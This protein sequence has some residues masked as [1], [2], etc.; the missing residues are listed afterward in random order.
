MENDSFTDGINLENNTNNVLP[1]PVED[2][3]EKPEN[4]K[5][6]TPLETEDGRPCFADKIFEALDHLEHNFIFRKMGIAFDYVSRPG[7]FPRSALPKASEVKE[8]KPNSA[9]IGT[10]I[11]ECIN[12]TCLLLDG[13]LTRLEL[14]LSRNDE[15]RIM[16]RLVAGLI[17]LGTISQKNR[18]V[19]GFTPDGRSYYN[20]YS[21][22]N[23]TW[24]AHGLYRTSI[25]P[26][27]SQ[28]SQQKL[29]DIGNKWL[30]ALKEDEFMIPGIVNDK[31]SL[32]PLES[33]SDEKKWENS[34]RFLHI[35]AV[36][37]F[38]TDNKEWQELYQQYAFTETGEFSIKADLPTAFNEP[39]KLLSLQIALSD[40][41]KIRTEE[42]ELMH[43]NLLR[44]KIAYRCVDTLKNFEP[45]EIT[46]NIEDAVLDWREGFPAGDALLHELKEKAN[47]TW[48]QIGLEMQRIAPAIEAA[49]CIM[50]TEDS[51]LISE[52]STDIQ[53]IIKNTEWSKL[54]TAC[55]I[56]PLLLMHALGYESSLWDYSRAISL[57][58]RT[59]GDNYG[60]DFDE[61]NREHIIDEEYIK[62]HYKKRS[63]IFPAF[64]ENEKEGGNG[65][66]KTGGKSRT[67]RHKKRRTRKR[68]K[69]FNK[70][71]N[72]SNTDKKQ[73]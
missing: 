70:N 22:M 72:S 42:K 10:G 59:I 7:D 11:G 49:L 23:C 55:S 38:L 56:S 50:L 28:E 51:T 62:K 36:I 73:N 41:T 21:A 65:N 52:N 37:T 61:E 69:S 60:F 39:N 63:S 8:N 15:A 66:S 64:I 35:L 33:L 12:N 47:N 45:V 57:S 3:V 53:N 25:T 32:L 48:P 43:L 46:V 5:E 18:I 26:T 1:I 58:N 24:Y 30:I 13:Y 27:V 54:W 6:D 71:S 19:R 17:R 68:T 4:I 67:K 44:K 14:G 31:N 16:D 34:I 40:L 9:G 29:K 20:S 2:D